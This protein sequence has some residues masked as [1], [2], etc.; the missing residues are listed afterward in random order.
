MKFKAIIEESDMGFH[1]YI[2]ALYGCVYQGLSFEDCKNGIKNSAKAYLD[3]L[4]SEEIRRIK[5][6]KST[7]VEID[8][9]E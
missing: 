2:P 5:G 1:A 8:L 4:P 3:H 7:I 6:I 9:S